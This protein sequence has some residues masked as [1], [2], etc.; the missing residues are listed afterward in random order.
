MHF[1]LIRYVGYFKW[2][3]IAMTP[4]A[5]L[6]TA[7]LIYFRHPSSH[8][9]YLVMCQLFNGLYS[10]V[11][12]MTAQL[13]IMAS[14]SHQEIAVAIALFGL[15]GSIGAAVGQA[16]AGALW[17]NVLPS[18]LLK[19]LPDELKNQT[20]AI[21][22]DIT[23]QLGFPVGT[24]ARDAIIASYGH[25]QR[26]MVIAGCAFLPVCIACLFMWRNINVNTVD[27]KNRRKQANVF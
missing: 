1:S 3:S 4:F 11:W 15:F 17:T 6:G 16:I 19:N 7:L 25:V 20:T 5:V 9:G 12:A 14:V 18:Q 26:L 24:P 27:A 21:Y 23:V 13:A 22:S 8:V 2:P 10:G